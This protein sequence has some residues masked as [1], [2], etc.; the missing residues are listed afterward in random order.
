VVSSPSTKR[1]A[2]TV[3]YRDWPGPGPC[4]RLYPCADGWIFVAAAATDEDDLRQAL[5][6]SPRSGSRFEKEIMSALTDLTVTESLDR[7]GLSDS[8][9]PRC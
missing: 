1:P 4:H 2:A 7:L 5:D 9:P 8:R 3:G 6:V